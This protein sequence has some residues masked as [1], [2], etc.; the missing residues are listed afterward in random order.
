MFCVPNT[1]LLK[2]EDTAYHFQWK[3]GVGARPNAYLWLITTNHYTTHINYDHTLFYTHILLLCF[4]Y[5][6]STWSPSETPDPEMTEAPKRQEMSYNQHV[7]KRKEERGCLYA[8]FVHLLSTGFYLVLYFR[9]R[10][11]N[12]YPISAYRVN[13]LCGMNMTRTKILP[14]KSDDI[15]LESYPVSEI[16]NSYP[17]SE[18]RVYS[19]IRYR[20]ERLK[21]CPI[22]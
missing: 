12:T 14:D 21:Y 22:W 2:L 11:L 10:L 19:C 13:L 15:N 5:V 7:Q 9:G 4:F 3:W 6:T 20:F 17:V 8:W 16:N 18:Y 1:Q